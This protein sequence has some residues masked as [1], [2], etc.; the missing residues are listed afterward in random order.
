MPWPAPLDDLADYVPGFN[1]YGPVNG[2]PYVCAA[3]PGI[4]ST[5]DL[6]RMVARGPRPFVKR[7]EDVKPASRSSR[8]RWG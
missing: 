4:L 8:R 1:A 3:A 7:L 5:E 6:P 2:I